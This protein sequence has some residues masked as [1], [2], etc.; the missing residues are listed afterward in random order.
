MYVVLDSL[1][2]SLGWSLEQ[3]SHVHVE[4]AVGITGCYYLRTTV[5]TVLTHLGNHDTGLT[6]FLLGKLLAEFTC[7][8]EVCIALTF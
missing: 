2:S 1:T 8:S 5:V 3:R 6:A 7:L 4:T